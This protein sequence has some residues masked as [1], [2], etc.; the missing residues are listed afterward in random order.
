MAKQKE[1]SLIEHFLQG[2]NSFWSKLVCVGAMFYGGFLFGTWYEG[3]RLSREY[4]EIEG[5]KRE[6]WSKRENEYNKQIIEQ[7][8]DI[9]EKE[10]I[11][12]KYETGETK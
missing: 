4:A 12:K 2:L 7:L 3:G 10:I 5:Q 8:A 9:K 6:E 11:I 1:N